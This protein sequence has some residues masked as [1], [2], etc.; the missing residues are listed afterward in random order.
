MSG[1]IYICA[2]GCMS[3]CAHGLPCMVYASDAEHPH[4]KRHIAY[5]ADDDKIHEWR[6]WKGRGKCEITDSPQEA[7]T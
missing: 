1:A 3:D 7:I 4:P 2:I 6:G 5:D